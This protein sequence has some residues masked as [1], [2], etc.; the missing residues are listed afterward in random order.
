MR[1]LLDLKDAGC[2]FDILR[3]ALSTFAI[4]AAARRGFAGRQ[5]IFDASNLAGTDAV[6]R[7]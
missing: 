3:V 4:H 7:V 2:E 5:G 1:T 6:S